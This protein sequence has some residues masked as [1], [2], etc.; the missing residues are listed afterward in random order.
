MTTELPAGLRRI[1]GHPGVPFAAEVWRVVEGMGIPVALVAEEGGVMPPPF[2]VTM[3]VDEDNVMITWAVPREERLP[4]QLPPHPSEISLISL[5]PFPVYDHIPDH[6]HDETDD[7]TEDQ[8]DLDLD[9]DTD[10]DT[11]TDEWLAALQAAT[12]LTTTLAGI[13]V[14]LGYAVSG[15]SLPDDPYPPSLVVVPSEG[16]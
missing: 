4:E 5:D 16:V 9:T 7:H 10:T 2:G 3:A 13:L 15:V 1:D 14:T 12:T 6:I 8:S 11:D